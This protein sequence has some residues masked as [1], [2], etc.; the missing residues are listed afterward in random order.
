MRLFYLTGV[1]Y[2]FCNFYFP[3]IDQDTSCESDEEETAES[4]GDGANE[5]SQDLP[6]NLG[7]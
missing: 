5:L 6:G 7:V 2:L 3:E 1:K 4:E